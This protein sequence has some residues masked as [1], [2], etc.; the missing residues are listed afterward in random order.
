MRLERT[1]RQRTSRVRWSAT[2]L[3]GAPASACVESS[4]RDVHCVAMH[5]TLLRWTTSWQAVV[6]D[7]TC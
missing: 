1:A 4:S 5:G 2:T 7:T 3:A 6:T